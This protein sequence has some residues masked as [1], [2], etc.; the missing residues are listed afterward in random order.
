MSVLS[1]T[2]WEAVLKWAVQWTEAAGWVNKDNGHY[3]LNA[4]HNWQMS[5]DSPR[6]VLHPLLLTPS[7]EENDLSFPACYIS[8]QHYSVS[9]FRMFFFFFVVL[10]HIIWSIKVP[11]WCLTPVAAPAGLR[12]H[13]ISAL[14]TMKRIFCK[15]EM[16]H[17]DE[18]RLNLSVSS[19]ILC[20][21]F[22]RGAPLKQ[23]RM[24]L[25]GNTSRG[26]WIGCWWN[27]R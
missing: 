18:R 26:V 7:W 12:E 5:N 4:Y 22:F 24:L 2:G 13:S 10:Q 27:K 20:F 25:L 16:N 15:W 8:E 14:Q 9:F 21:C 17:S 1:S 23:Y 6:Q 11:L 3:L 19:L